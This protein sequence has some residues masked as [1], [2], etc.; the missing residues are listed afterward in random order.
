MAVHILALLTL[1]ISR[2][3]ILNKIFQVS[4]ESVVYIHI[5]MGYLF[6]ALLLTHVVAWVIVWGQD[7]TGLDDL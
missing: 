5:K 1:P 6:I 3:S 4:W 2:T 7:G